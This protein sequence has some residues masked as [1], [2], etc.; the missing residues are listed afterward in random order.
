MPSKVRVSDQPPHW[1]LR[2][3]IFNF[4]SGSTQIIVKMRVQQQ[5]PI[6]TKTDKKTMK[7]LIMSPT[8]ILLPQPLP[9][10]VGFDL[11]HQIVHTS[12]HYLA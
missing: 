8:M 11:M 7:R 5:A 3:V 2:I 9:N 6:P 4:C 12:I 10:A 1:K